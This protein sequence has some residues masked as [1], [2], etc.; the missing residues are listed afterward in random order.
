[1]T[2]IKVT[3]SAKQAMKAFSQQ[4]GDTMFA[5]YYSCPDDE[6][7]LD[8]SSENSDFLVRYSVTEDGLC[9]LRKPDYVDGMP[10]TIESSRELTK[11]IKLAGE[12]FVA[13]S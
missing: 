6:E 12:Y 7:V 8:I 10:A 5:E 11:A 4:A 9:L 3:E 13:A 1:M 2:S